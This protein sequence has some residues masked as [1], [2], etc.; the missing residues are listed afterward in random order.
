VVDWFTAILHA[1]G[2]AAPADRVIDGVDQLDL[3]E[4]PAPSMLPARRAS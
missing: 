4:S 1:A 3:A 2:L